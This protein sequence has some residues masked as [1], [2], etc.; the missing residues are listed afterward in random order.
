MLSDAALQSPRTLRSEPRSASSRTRVERM[1]EGKGNGSK[2]CRST[3]EVG[4][5]D[6]KAYGRTR[7]TPSAFR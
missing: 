6:Q 3:K 7:S 4:L 1:E 5:L 2:F